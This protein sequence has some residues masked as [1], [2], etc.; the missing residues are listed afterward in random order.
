[1]EKTS[2]AAFKILIGII[3]I[4]LG[5]YFFTSG[6]HEFGTLDQMILK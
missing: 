6:V 2:K 3:F 5:I 1:M 4:L